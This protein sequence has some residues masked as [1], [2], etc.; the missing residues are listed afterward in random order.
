M[1]AKRLQ[2]DSWSA[3]RMLT[4]KEPARSTFGQLVEDLSGKNATIGGSSDTDVNEPMT[5]P[6]GPVS[7]WTAVT[8]HTPVGYCPRT[9][10][11]HPE[12]IDRPGTGDV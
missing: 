9:V 12:S 3:P 11:N 8:T 5:I 6:A 1:A 4:Q 2:T 10:R 7:G